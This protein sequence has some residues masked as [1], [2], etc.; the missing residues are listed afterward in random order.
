[1]AGLW[2]LWKDRNGVETL[3]FTMLMLNAEGH[4]VFGR[5]HPP[6]DEKRMPVI[7]HRADYDAWLN[8]AVADADAFIQQFPAELLL[9]EPDPAPWKQL[10]EPKSWAI[11]T[12]M[13]QEE[14]KQ[15]AE[16][17]KARM[18]KA[19]RGRAKP[20]DELPPEAG[21]ETGDLF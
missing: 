14:W 21:P 13:F 4:G 9:A 19:R 10:P 3:S 11:S 1:V 2:R 18:L 6:N 20:K 15:A 16:D 5:M 7:L 8:C 12:D 17:P